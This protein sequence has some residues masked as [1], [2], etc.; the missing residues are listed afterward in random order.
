MTLR[1]TQFYSDM[2]WQKN[3]VWFNHSIDVSI[4]SQQSMTN[5]GFPWLISSYR[6]LE[7][8]RNEISSTQL[9][10]SSLHYE[11]ST[12]LSKNFRIMTSFVKSSSDAPLNIIKFFDNWYMIKAFT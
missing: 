6:T 11:Q 1:K 9:N 7:H 12:F 2:N 5:F 8:Y 10:V 3:V 4:V